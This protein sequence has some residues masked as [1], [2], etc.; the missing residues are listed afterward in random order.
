MSLFYYSIYLFERQ[1][2]RKKRRYTEISCLVSSPNDSKRQKWAQP[3]PA[4]RSFNWV[5]QVNVDGKPLG[6]C[7]VV[8]PGT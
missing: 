8:F 2:Y 3:K 7:F 4:V 1:N 6:P 5:S